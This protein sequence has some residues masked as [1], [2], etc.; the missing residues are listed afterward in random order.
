MDIR[1]IAFSLIAASFPL[2]AGGAFAQ[3]GATVRSGAGISTAT[4]NQ[5]LENDFTSYR[6]GQHGRDTVQESDIA[7]LQSEIVALKAAAQELATIIDQ[8]QA[9][10]DALTNFD[11]STIEA[12]QSVGISPH[13]YAYCPAETTLISGGCASN[14][15]AVTNTRPTFP[16][17][18]YKSEAYN[19]WSCMTERGGV[20]YALCRRLPKK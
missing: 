19:G 10:I 15:G 9:T 7:L 14:S 8:Q 3:S 11:P 16:N 13:A 5:R 18:I 4:S 1:F 12:V 6:A 17:K 2:F 20:A